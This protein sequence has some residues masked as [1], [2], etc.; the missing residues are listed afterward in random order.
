VSENLDPRIVEQLE[1]IVGK[2]E[3]VTSRGRLQNY[4]LDETPAP[5]RPRPADDLALVRPINAQ[6]VCEVLQLANK[7]R[8]PVFPR[9]GGT[10]L[11]GGAVPNRAGMILS[12]ERMTKI[13]ID[14]ANMMAV[15]EAG[16]TLDR[17]VKAADEL[18]LSF[19]PHP[20]DE[21]AQVGGM[22]ATN[23]GGSRA[24]RHGVMRNQV[25]EMEVVLPTGEIL[26]LGRKVHKNNVGYDL[27]QLLIGSEGTLGVITKATLQLY[28]KCGASATMIL[29]F[30]NRRDAISIVPSLLRNA[31]TPLAVEFVGRK[32]MERTAERLGMHWPVSHG[33]SCLI[34]ILAELTHDEILAE[35]L[36]ISE[37][38][39]QN[40]NFQP[41]LAE[42]KTDQD[43]ILR[44]RSSIYSILKTQSMDILDS[45]VP[46]AELENV[47]VQIEAV[48]RRHEVEL[49]VYGHA[50]DGNLHVHIMRRDGIGPDDVVR[51]TNEIYEITNRAGGVITGEHGIG[52]IRTNRVPLFFSKKELEIM[53]A[54]KNTLDPNGIMNPGTKIVI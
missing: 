41:Y 34:I 37:I 44:I 11:V 24:V 47:V 30:A 21:S 12:L 39:K 26:N 19:P 46:I 18:G 53:K 43:K 16:V 36:K 5:V 52:K 32:L 8:I 9:G 3:V 48:S 29:P 42:S 6:Q 45:T 17:L 49:H 7:H 54:L 31:G 1:R 33:E 38:C 13:A 14:S 50:A 2:E 22:I 27:M 51:I 4:L 23:A 20:G 28:P 15:S 40:T 25:R 10:G 35:A